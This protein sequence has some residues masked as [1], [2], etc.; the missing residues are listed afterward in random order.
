MQIESIALKLRPRT[1]WEGCDLGVRLLQSWFG[2]V[3]R[4]AYLRHK[5]SEL[6]AGTLREYLA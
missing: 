5:R 6:S 4:D 3:F 2:P 1:V